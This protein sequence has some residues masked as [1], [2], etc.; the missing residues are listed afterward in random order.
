MP[1][2]WVLIALA[3][4]LLMGAAV[5]RSVHIRESRRLREAEERARRAERLAELGAMTGGLA[6]EIKNPLSTIGLNAQLIAEG[7]AELRV[8][9]DDED[10]KPRLINRVGALR[11]E[12]ERLRGILQD[13]LEYAGSVRL[14][15]RPTDLN[16]AAVELVDFL[17]PEA[18]RAGVRLRADLASGEVIAPVDTRLL[19]QA[20]LNLLLNAIQAVKG[21]GG[22]DG[23]PFKG[24][25]ILRTSIDGQGESG[26]KAAP[27]MAAVRV[28]DTGPGIPAETL[29]RIFQPYFTTKGGGT[30]LGLPTAR[31]LIE[32]HGGT[33]TVD[34]AP[35]RGTTFIAT[36]PLVERP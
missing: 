36:L 22:A 15:K 20:L 27:A 33:L 5:A 29:P 11:R 26:G 10:A 9:A 35:G 24:E 18:E 31:R 34:S 16:A 1:W 21:A 30:G 7:I 25:V 8:S 28:I 23:T 6:H 4:G 17:T 19:K 32:E 12:T 13:F 14:E 3:V 2:P